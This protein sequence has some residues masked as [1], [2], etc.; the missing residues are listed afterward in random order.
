MAKRHTCSNRCSM[1]PDCRKR[2]VLSSATIEL[3]RNRDTQI[4]TGFEVLLWPCPR[5]CQISRLLTQATTDGRGP[6]PPEVN[7]ATSDAIGD[8]AAD[9]KTKRD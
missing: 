7:G 6:V 5:L 2:V 8:E 4:G 9:Q 1:T 3:A